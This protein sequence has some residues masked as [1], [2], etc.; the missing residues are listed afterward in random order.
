LAAPALF[1]YDD[2]SPRSEHYC[3]LRNGATTVETT[4]PVCIGPSRVP[5]NRVLCRLSALTQFSL[6]KHLRRIIAPSSELPLL[7]KKVDEF[8]TKEETEIALTRSARHRGALGA[9]SA[10][11]E[12]LSSSDYIAIISAKG[13]SVKAC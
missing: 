7:M 8:Y 11:E 4:R 12:P 9:L 5:Q 2:E 13:F 10:A 6:L 1:P 3:G